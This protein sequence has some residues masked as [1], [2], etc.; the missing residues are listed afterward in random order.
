MKFGTIWMKFG[1]IAKFGQWWNQ[2]S[3][4][5]LKTPKGSAKEGF[6]PDSKPC[7]SSSCSL[8]Q[9][10]WSPNCDGYS[11]LRWLHF[12]PRRRSCQ[13]FRGLLWRMHGVFVWGTQESTQQNQVDQGA[14]CHPCQR[15]EAGWRS[16][17]AWGAP[18]SCGAH[19]SCGAPSSGGA[20][21]SGGAACA[22]SAS[23]AN[24][25]SS[26]SSTQEKKDHWS[27]WINTVNQTTI[28]LKYLILLN[29]ERF[30]NIIL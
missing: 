18:S 22:R 27:D 3:A 17:R 21:S 8:E 5:Q 14:Q 23:T 12:L 6:L 4:N 24:T 28:K 15:F 7:E 10:I 20:S 26:R 16:T 1:T 29:I 11:S 13:C 30:T 9:P 2:I 25:T 19:S